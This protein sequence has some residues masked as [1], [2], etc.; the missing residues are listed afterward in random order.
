MRIKMEEKIQFRIIKETKV[1]D[2]HT[3]FPNPAHFKGT[4]TQN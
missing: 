4:G 3:N 1:M 2:P